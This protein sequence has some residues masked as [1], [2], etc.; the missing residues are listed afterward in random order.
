VV[1]GSAGAAID[2]GQCNLPDAA[3]DHEGL[4]TTAKKVPMYVLAQL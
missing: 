4:I 1:I 2:G 3:P